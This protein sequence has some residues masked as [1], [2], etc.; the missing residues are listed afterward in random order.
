MK[1]A[2][3]F[4]LNGEAIRLEDVSPNTPLLDWLR[5]S[6]RTGSKEGCAEGD[7][8]ACSVAMVDADA[9]GKPV[10]R[11][12]N[13][14]LTPLALV[15]GREVVTV[16]GLGNGK[17]HPVQQCMV[18]N[19]GSQC[20]YCTPGIIMSMFEGYYRD[21]LKKDW[22]LNDQLCGNLCRCTG[23][24]PIR[25]A[26][27]EAWSAAEKSAEDDFGRRC[28]AAKAVPASADYTRGSEK[29]FRPGSLEELFRLRAQQPE[30]RLI[31]GATELGLEI[32][33][34]FKKFPTLISVESV[35]ELR[36][37]EKKDGAW[38]IGGAVTLTQLGDAIA[39]DFP[40]WAKM[41]WVFG[42]R[43]IRNRATLGG[44]LV[45]ASPIGDSA[46]VLLAL[47][48]SVVLASARG[49][50]TVPLADFF[51]SYRKTAMAEDEILLEVVVPVTAPAKG[52]FRKRDWFKV[53]KRREMDISTVS[54]CFS[55][56]T[57]SDG[58]VAVAR[59]A[60]GGVAATPARARKTEDFLIGKEWN[61]DTVREACGILS[62]EFQP[63][64]D[65][66]G[67]ADYRAG[68]ITSLLEKFYHEPE[69]SES[70]E[71]LPEPVI[72]PD[73]SLP[74]ESGHKHV[75]GEALYVDDLALRSNRALEV[76]PVHS[77]HAHARILRRDATEARKMP[78]IHAVLMAEDVP[79]LND[80][81]AVRKDEELLADKV[82]QFHGHI[83]A[84]VVGET[85]DQ[86]RAAAEKV[87]VE[88]EALEPVL[89][90]E[91]GIAKDSFHSEPN[92]MR[93][94][95]VDAALSKAPRVMEGNFSL[96][97]QEH[98]YL[99]MQAA[100]AEP[101]EDGTVQVTSSTQHPTEV[102]HGV[103]HVL[104]IP[105]NQV[106][107]K[108]TR[109]GGGFGGKETQAATLAA[110]AALAAQRTGRPVR[111][112]YNRDQ[113]MMLTG[114]RHPF[115]AK[116]T[117]GYDDEGR[118]L[119]LKAALYSNGGWALDLSMPVTDRA[120]F[121]TDNSYF[122]PNVE[123]QGRVVKTNLVSNTAFRGFGGPQGMLI[124]EEI[125]DRIA[126]ETG[127]PP[128]V[129]RE[130][131]LYHGSGETNTTHYGQEI[132]DNRIQQVWHDLKNSADLSARRAE[133]AAWNAA[134]P[135]RK[136]GLAMTPVKFG[137]S[138][139]NTI[140][141]QAGALV[142]VYTDG[143]AQVNHGGTEMGQGINTNMTAI[144]AQALGIPQEKIR[145]MSTVTD[146]VP[147]TSATAASSGTDMNGMAVKDACDKI[148]ERLRPV[149]A[150]M[151]SAKRGKT[152]GQNDVEFRDGRV[153][154]VNHPGDYFE[155]HEVTQKAWMQRVSLAATGYYRT[156]EIHWDRNA[157]QGHPFYY[158][159][160]G[161][162]VSEVEVD[163]F[164][165]EMQM[166]RVDILQD[167]GTSI[168]EA[169]NRGQVEGGFVQGLGWLTAEELVWNREGKL[170]THSP[171]TYKIPAVGDVPQDF[172]VRLLEDAPN[173]KKTIH[174]SKAV[175]EP[176]FMLAISVREAIRDAV[177]AFGPGGRQVRLASPA[178][179][180]AIF[181]AI[182]EQRMPDVQGA[183]L[184]A[185]PRGVLV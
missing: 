58:K 47:D 8:G 129:V 131:N 105:S 128:E 179:G 137:I 184:E 95:D 48:A 17:L 19:H 157:G 144:A 100:Y 29:F 12:F 83:V 81:G 25:Q 3:E 4:T 134:N 143:S 107:I 62:K 93:R 102:Q 170:L 101:G 80:V 121:H 72:P 73:R 104:G 20:G 146:K 67:S 41:L 110:L 59:L 115:L 70:D 120:M 96:G 161:A 46:P 152:C 119:A 27:L 33:K 23:Y 156:P 35:P 34:R 53:S 39:E 174:R 133:I 40:M 153:F 16:E 13:S 181:R 32:S 22:Q 44:N 7:C 2:L 90:I 98:F 76:W 149:A 97:G 123:L 178:T 69:W 5:A 88:Y 37:L 49:Q 78:G 99:E 63:I 160:V 77:P 84:L 68:L 31:A 66:R 51:L 124:I 79:G 9:E 145:V 155:F 162:A 113:D 132:E 165:G 111:M 166:R 6:G 112:R 50:R 14:C 138:F 177:A 94:G 164:T 28:D 86:C 173:P 42:S 183:P 167:V 91:D 103:A 136:R 140:L 185:V 139:T 106:V 87:V 148:I 85:A 43:Q 75:N 89:T 125:L 127:L 1:S 130:R 169:I 122:I 159:A 182:R 168:N 52:Q 117:I 54:G 82:A 71:P 158:F 154:H 74:H 172:R 45:T 18:A 141:N 10:W 30:G 57:G 11:S 116:F 109:M 147:N 151:L 114:K 180:E 26:A 60:F 135:H 126:R 21:D 108:V 61:E 65:A 175:G 176:P 36:R 171:D 118:L 163:G 38:R 150:E 15:H 24:R 92:F 56:E 142:L 55:I 64:T